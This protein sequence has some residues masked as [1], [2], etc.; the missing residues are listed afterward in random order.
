MC[1]NVRTYKSLWVR[2][3]CFFSWVVHCN[4][5]F[6][7]KNRKPFLLTFLLITKMQTNIQ[8]IYIDTYYFQGYLW[9]KKDE[10]EN[11]TA[12]FSE[13]ES[14]V[15][16]NPEINVKIPFIVI[17]ELINNL[18]LR[19]NFEQRERNEIMYNFFELRKDLDADIIP[20][21]KYSFD[22]AKLLIDQ[23][24]YLEKHPSDVLIASCALCDSDSSH[25]LIH[26]K[27]LLQS[28]ELKKIEK[29]MRGEG[30]RNRQLKIT[31]EL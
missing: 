8:N 10:K 3:L 18:V 23:D 29:D 7:V 30:K 22:K 19:E 25:L 6:P 12:I 13:I 26:D 27:L 4:S 2:L 1:V 21:N 11:T 17:G 9:G 24:N 20:P 16:K 15:R 14:N 31:E 28:L 5:Y